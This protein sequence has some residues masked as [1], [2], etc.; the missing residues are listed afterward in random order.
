MGRYEL[1]EREIEYVVGVEKILK[2]IDRIEGEKRR[3]RVRMDQ[4]A[5]ICEQ[6][7]STWV[8]E[9]VRRIVPRKNK[10]GTFSKVVYQ[11]LRQAKAPMK[12]RDISKIMAD[13]L[14]IEPIQRE[15]NRLDNM[16]M[17]VLKPRIGKTVIV[18]SEKPRQWAVM[19]RDQVIAALRASQATPAPREKVLPLKPTAHHS[20]SPPIASETAPQSRI[21]ET[22]A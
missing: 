1:I 19:P 8:R 18:V 9:R 2:E 20:G 10:H 12:S 6:L 7:D 22:H 13:R 5:A 11:I 21:A 15:L 3:M 17:G 16:V 4:I 14:G